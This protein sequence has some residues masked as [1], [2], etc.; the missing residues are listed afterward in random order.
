M[1]SPPQYA[2]MDAAVDRLASLDLPRDPT[3]LPDAQDCVTALLLAV[4][5]PNLETV[6]ALLDHGMPLSSSAHVR[7][8]LV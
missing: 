5:Q 6:V 4:S 2:P 3:L 8:C 7:K 1:R